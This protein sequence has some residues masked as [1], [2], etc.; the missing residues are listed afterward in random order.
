[1]KNVQ[2]HVC[3]RRSWINFE[4]RFGETST[5]HS[6]IICTW[7]NIFVKMN[8]SEMLITG[9]GVLVLSKCRLIG[10]KWEEDWGHN[11]ACFILHKK[12]NAKWSDAVIT[13]FLSN[14]T[15][16]NSFCLSNLREVWT[17]LVKLWNLC[18]IINPW[19]W[20]LISSSI[21]VQFKQTDIRYQEE[22]GTSLTMLLQETPAPDTDST[23]EAEKLFLWLISPVTASDFFR[24]VVYWDLLPR[25]LCVVLCMYKNPVHLS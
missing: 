10:V 19:K 13:W 18:F 17:R 11:V 25:V 22:P 7:V 24:W 2:T 21:L 4:E 20:S 6:T 16:N 14:M 15:H 9:S 3:L 1:M 23:L 8:D 12:V 5:A